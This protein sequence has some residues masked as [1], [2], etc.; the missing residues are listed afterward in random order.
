MP[1][2]RKKR[3]TDPGVVYAEPFHPGMI[4]RRRLFEPLNISQK[5][6]CEKYGISETKFSRILNGNQPIT[7]D[8]AI[9]FAKAFGIS[10][11]FFM[12]LRN[13]HELEMAKRKRG[14]EAYSGQGHGA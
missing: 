12:N 6:F 5:K 8:T 11:M 9:E 13:R 1:Q 10:E 14:A 3:A 7:A 2:T 4:I